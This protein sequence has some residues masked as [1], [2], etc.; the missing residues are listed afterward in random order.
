MK[1]KRSN[2][3][4]FYRTKSGKLSNFDAPEE[5]ESKEAALALCKASSKS[6]NDFER[7]VNGEPIVKKMEYV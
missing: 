4:V 6:F 2:W 5:V 7:G 1:V 3:L